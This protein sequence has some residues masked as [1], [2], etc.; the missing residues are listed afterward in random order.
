MLQR[1]IRDRSTG[2]LPLGD[3]AGDVPLRPFRL[4]LLEG[5]IR[6]ASASG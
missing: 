4:G 3:Q 5:G 6:G 1:K 2:G